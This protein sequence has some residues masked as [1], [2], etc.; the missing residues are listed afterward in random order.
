MVHAQTISLVLTVMMDSTSH[1]LNALSVT[2]AVRLVTLMA[3]L[4]VPQTILKMLTPRLVLLIAQFSLV[5]VSF[6]L[7]LTSVQD[8]HQALLLLLAQQLVLNVQ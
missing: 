6:V 8:A 1:H 7:L 4:N 5:T 2:K 3:A